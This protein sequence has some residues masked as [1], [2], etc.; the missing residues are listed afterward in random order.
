MAPL[1]LLYNHYNI[2][3]AIVN[4]LG[5]GRGKGAG[6]WYLILGFTK[7]SFTELENDRVSS[8]YFSSFLTSE[9]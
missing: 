2:E 9:Y 7:E 8:S 1:F 4:R 3:V 5:G 6:G